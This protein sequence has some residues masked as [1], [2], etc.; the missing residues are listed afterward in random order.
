MGSR[1]VCGVFVGGVS[2]L[3]MTKRM[4]C[5]GQMEQNVR[6]GEVRREGRK[7]GKKL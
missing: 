2:G 3:R 4:Y 7:K 1:L 6:T 5:V